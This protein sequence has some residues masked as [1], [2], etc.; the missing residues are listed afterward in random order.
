VPKSWIEA[1]SPYVPGRSSGEG[2]PLVKLSANENPLGCSPAAAAARREA[3]NAAIYPDPDCDVLRQAIGSIHSIDPAR[4]VCGT[5]SGELL[6]L[7]AQGFAGPGDEIVF[8]RYAFSLYPLCARRCGAEPVEAAGEGFGADVDAI[9]SAVGPATRAVFIANPNNP[10]G[11]YLGRREVA[12][13][14]RGL[15]P[16]V[17]LV[18]DRAYADYVDPA[19]DDGALELAEA[20]GNILVTHTFS[21]IHGLAADRV[22]WAFG[23]PRIVD[24]LNRIRGPFNVSATGQ[25]AALAAIQ[26]GE[27]VARARRHNSVERERF[28]ARLAGLQNAGITV[29][30]SRANFVLVCFAG[31]PGAKQAA[32]ALERAGYAV[33]H[34]ASEGLDQALRITIGTREQMDAVADVIA[35]LVN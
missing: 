32:A 3:G 4:I 13:L 11:T 5:G 31:S 29:L 34:F 10:T 20:A 26:D 12:R 24:V 25:A 30:P 16:S 2:G 1:I 18:I 15:D 27:F 21:K 14:H 33:R 8:P 28:A 19:D 7:A 9:L 6:Y 22:G 35:D 17:L 23:A